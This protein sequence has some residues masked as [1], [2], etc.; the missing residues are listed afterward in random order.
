VTQATKTRILIAL[1]ATLAACSS[2]PAAQV[3]AETVAVCL[4]CGERPFFGFADK[5]EATPNDK[6][7][8]GKAGAL[9]TK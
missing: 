8:S 1:C 2:T 6:P 7:G 9:V 5:A 3:P 4:N